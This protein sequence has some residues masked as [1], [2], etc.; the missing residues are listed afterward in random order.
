METFHVCPSPR[1]QAP[2]AESDSEASR[3]EAA[4]LDD[5]DGRSDSTMDLPGGGP[6]DVAPVTEVDSSDESDSDESVAN[7][8]DMRDSQRDSWWGNAYNYWNKEDKLDKMVVPIEALYQWMVDGYPSQM[9]EAYANAFCK[10]DVQLLGC[11][12][13]VALCLKELRYHVS[14]QTFGASLHNS[15]FFGFTHAGSILH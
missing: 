10:E 1:P 2:P 14:K 13:N 4:P 7:E 8:V 6:G 12:L 9:S 3:A 15:S 5:D 11:A